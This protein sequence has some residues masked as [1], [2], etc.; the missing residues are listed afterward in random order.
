MTPGGHP[1]NNVKYFLDGSTVLGQ[2]VSTTG[3]DYV[4]HWMVM[5]VGTHSITAT[6]TGA[7]SNVA[8]TTAYFT[9]TQGAP[10]AALIS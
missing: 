1:I 10:Q 5:S 3:G 9:I 4:F 8:S 7:R 2:G 6:A